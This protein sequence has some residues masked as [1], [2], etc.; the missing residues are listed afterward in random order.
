M[1]LPALSQSPRDPAFVQN[2]YPFYD[3]ARALGPL[4][5]WT[6]YGMPCAAGHDL[7]SALLR[8]RRFGREVPESRRRPVPEHLVPFQA[9]E[10]HSLLE[11]EPP[12]HTR[13]R[14]LVL[15]AFTSR[16]IVGLAPEIE[17][18][19]HQLID[20]FAGDRVELISQFAEPLPVIIIARL[21]GLP[22]DLAPQLLDW[23]HKMVA[24]YQARR[25]EAVERAA[26]KASAE[27]AACLHEQIE[28]RRRAPGDDLLSELIAARDDQDRLTEAEMISTIV[29]L[30]N[31]GHEATVHTIGNGTAALLDAGIT[32]KPDN[33][34]AVAEEILR[35][36]PPLHM[37][38]RYAREDVDIAGHRFRKDDEV[39]LLLAAAGRDPEAFPEPN[40]FD[41][42]RPL[43][44]VHAAFG[45][46][47]HFCVGAPLARAELAIALPILFA[48]CPGLALAEPPRFA[49][50]YHFHGLE[51][52]DLKI[53]P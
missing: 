25:D 46:G 8:D 10:E 14:K 30:L 44:P 7:V 1:S 3:R 15:R 22:D 21:M 52:L 20:R 27:F 33:A 51:R 23:S 26:G 34:E 9:I 11:L 47:I 42:V 38:T 13:L 48:R 17:A 50:R 5:H 12:S 19:A 36:D 43:K 31:A 35:Y 16:R 2:P 41:P 28:A 49:D 53:A 37:F 32:P 24:M 39:G 45:A 6:D 18:L 4:F 29:L 40:R